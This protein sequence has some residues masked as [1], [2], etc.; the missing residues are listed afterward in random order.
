MKG[1]YLA[2][3][4]EAGRGALAGPVV[5]A[6]VVF[7]QSVNIEGLADSKKLSR[8]KRNLLFDKIQHRSIAWSIGYG[9]VEEIDSI[10]ILQATLLAMKRAVESLSVK[11][12]KLLVDGNQLPETDIDSEAVVR[13]DQ[14]IPVISAASIVAKVVRDK[15]M[16]EYDHQYPQYG[17]ARHVGYGTKI[18]LENLSTYGVCPIHR[19][20]FAPVRTQLNL[21]QWGM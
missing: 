4:D 20:S 14:Y 8:K 12:C 17:F 11:P 16:L 1:Q 19:K 5:S 15:I 2:G 3:I 6:A 18:H 10:N 21:A 13:G 7:D 9:S